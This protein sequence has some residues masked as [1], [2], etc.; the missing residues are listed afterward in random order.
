M[1]K[2]VLIILMFMVLIGIN[3]PAQPGKKPAWISR[4][5]APDREYVYFVGINT[6]ARSLESGREQAV[7]NVMNQIV[8]YIGVNVSARMIFQKSELVSRLTDE[9]RSYG[10]ADI[11]RAIITDMYYEQNERDGSFNVYLLTRYLKSEIDEE[12]ARM[13]EVVEQYD[14]EMDRAALEILAEFKNSSIGHILIGGFKELTSGDRYSFSSVLENAFKTRLTGGEAEITEDPG[15]EYLLTG[16]YYAQGRD[17][18]ISINVFNRNTM[19][20]IFASNI[21]VP[22]DALEPG[23]LNTGKTEDIFFSELEREPLEPERTGAI[24]VAS[25]PRG[26]KIY[27]DGEVWGKTDI[28]IHRLPIGPHNVTIIKDGYRVYTETVYVDEGRTHEINASLQA[29]KGV[30]SVKTIP[31]GAKFF[32]DEKYSGTTPQEIKGLAPGKYI[33]KLEKENYKKYSEIIEIAADE[34]T[35]KKVNLIEED[36]ALLITSTPPGAKVYIA[37]RFKGLASPLH[38]EKIAAG[39]HNLRIE[40]E[41]YLPWEKSVR[42]KAF[43]TQTI[44][45][46]LKKMQAGIIKIF[47]VPAYASIYVNGAKKGN[48]PLELELD[49]GVYRLEISKERYETWYKTVRVKAGETI[50][51]YRQLK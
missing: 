15:A 39:E 37:S 46:Q 31:S 10:K 12:R 35:E 36:G 33:I 18:K 27:I 42:V 26:A 8:A 2:S 19:L 25:S 45:A 5:P 29:Q 21:S 6:N 34:T 48:T 32:I 40:A 20:N 1:K 23:W 38:L 30:F 13:L 14:R 49:P 7:H 41:G 3:S 17:I 28:D 22:K 47:T 11:R 43:R 51:I 44:S 16:T 9:I 4:P 24:K 50:R